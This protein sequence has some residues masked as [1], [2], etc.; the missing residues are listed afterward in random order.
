M[1]KKTQIEIEAPIR[2]QS[3][4]TLCLKTM[5]PKSKKVLYKMSK[6]SNQE[7]HKVL[8]AVDMLELM[9]HQFLP[10][11]KDIDKILL[12]LDLFS[13][14]GRVYAAICVFHYGMIQGKRIERKKKISNI[15]NNR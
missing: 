4:R 13:Q 2:D 11:E 5:Q 10:K 7:F 8:E 14:K 1:K 15:K 12:I 6:L 9:S 3:N